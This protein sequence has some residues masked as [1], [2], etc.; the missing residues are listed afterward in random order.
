[1][2]QP[3]QESLQNVKQ[4]Y[5]DIEIGKICAWLKQRGLT[6]HVSLKGEIVF[7]DKTTGDIYGRV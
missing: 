3:E 1:M 7:R 4:P 6:M 2:D 5:Y